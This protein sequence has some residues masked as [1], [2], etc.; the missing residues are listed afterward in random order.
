MPDLG[1]AITPFEAVMFVIP[2]GHTVE[3]R[4]EMEHIY[5]LL[6]GDS[7]RNERTIPRVESLCEHFKL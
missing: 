3:N 6:F 1:Y 2:L 4:K 5:L 7:P